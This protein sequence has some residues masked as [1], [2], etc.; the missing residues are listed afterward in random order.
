MIDYLG[1]T[2]GVFLT[3]A[4][5]FVPSFIYAVMAT[6]QEFVTVRKH[7]G[8][9]FIKVWRHTMTWSCSRGHR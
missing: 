5:I 4:V 8:I 1:D 3:L 7:G 6:W 9:R 2:T